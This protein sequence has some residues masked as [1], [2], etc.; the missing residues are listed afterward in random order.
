MMKEGHCGQNVSVYSFPHIQT[1]LSEFRAL[2]IA[3][4]LEYKNVEE[5]TGRDL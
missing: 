5:L 3:N 4:M 2:F 1:S